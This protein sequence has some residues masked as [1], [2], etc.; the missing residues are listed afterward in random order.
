V[1]DLLT[2]YSSLPARLGASTFAPSTGAGVMGGSVKRTHVWARRIAAGLGLFAAALGAVA[3]AGWALNSELLRTALLGRASMAVNT[4]LGLIAAGL[5]L[6]LAATNPTPN[7]ALRTLRNLGATLV[8]ALGTAFLVEHFGDI[9]LGIDEVFARDPFTPIGLHPGRIPRPAAVGFVL[10]GFAVLF[11]F[12]ASRW[13]FWTGFTLTAIGFWITLFM[14]VGFM[15]SLDSIHGSAW[16][17]K[18]APQTAIAFLALFAGMMHAVPDR[19]WARIVLT[20]KL[21]GVVARRLLPL[22][23][24]LPLAIV[25]LAHKGAQLDYYS[26]RVG[27]YLGAVALLI[28]LTTVVIVICGRLNVLDA[29]R[30]VILEGRSR[31]QA[32]AVRMRQIAE[33]DVLTELWNRRHFLA[34]AEDQM[35]AARAACARLA[36]LM[37]DIDHFKRINDTHGHAGGDKALRLLGATL[38]D[39]TRKDDCAA[40]L[41]GEEFAVLLP[42]ASRAVAQNIAERICEQVAR[43]M[44]LDAEGRRFSFTV[45]IGL[46]EL[47]ESDTKAEDLLARADAALYQAK[48]GGR[49]RVELSPALERSAA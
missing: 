23:A 42:G 21:G 13:A 18:V 7:A 43:L 44:V 11:T 49:N 41:G 10:F 1:S 15:F 6:L 46:S 8:A 39:F 31:A 34:A 30:R 3:L 19:G 26:D 32:A 38:K 47:A 24:V 48:R 29:H 20:D 28:V 35:A 36:L 40:R 17:A 37:I 33:I 16:F 5:T 9:D 25:W 4:A 45:S 12:R 22:M 2:V 14:F 27:E